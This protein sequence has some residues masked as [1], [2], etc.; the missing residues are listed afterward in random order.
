MLRDL[1]LPLTSGATVCLPPEEANG[2]EQFTWIEAEQ[3]TVV[4]LV[5]S[6]ARFWLALEFPPMLLPH[7][8]GSSLQG[9]PSPRN[10]LSNGKQP[11]QGRHSL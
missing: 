3:I 8:D 1:F 10:F 6:I 4:H 7:Y 5:P 9:N 11:V 2:I